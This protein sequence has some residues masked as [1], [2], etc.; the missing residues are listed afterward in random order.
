LTAWLIGRRGLP[1]YETF[2][3][4]IKWSEIRQWGA[5]RQQDFSGCLSWF[6]MLSGAERVAAAWD[7]ISAADRLRGESGPQNNSA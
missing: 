7:A 4:L 6:S 5:R 1:T 2:D 3:E